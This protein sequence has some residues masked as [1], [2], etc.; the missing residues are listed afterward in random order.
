MII[1]KY[2]II[3]PACRNI[4]RIRKIQ[5]SATIGIEVEIKYPDFMELGGNHKIKCECDTCGDAYTQPINRLLEMSRRVDLCGKCMLSEASEK[6]KVTCKTASSR[7]KRSRACKEF[8]KTDVGKETTKRGGETYKIWA[9]SEEGQKYNISR[10]ERFIKMRSEYNGINHPR[11]NP[12]K[13][14]YN[15]Y[16]SEVYAHQNMQDLSNLAHINKPRT[17]CGVEG[18]WQLDHIVPLKYGFNNDI[19]PKEMGH[20]SNL[21]MMPWKENRTK[22]DDI[23]ESEMINNI[24]LRIYAMHAII[25]SI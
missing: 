8:Y 11:Y 6:M 14:L 7:L 12:D 15:K 2:I 22:S 25:I 19:S 5:P 4:N 10:T 23:S 13:S 21:E 3:R 1:S 24:S 17:L 18:G 20:I 16:K 9:A